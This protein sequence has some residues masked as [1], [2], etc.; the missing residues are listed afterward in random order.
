[1]RGA[2][3]RTRARVGRR[4][5]FLAF[6]AVLDA[7]FGYSL[8]TV[9]R[10]ALARADFILPVHAWGWTWIGTGVICASGILARKDRV[11]YTAAALLKTAW[12][13]LYAWLWWQGVPAAWVSV[14]VWLAFALVVVLVAGWPEEAAPPPPGP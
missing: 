2:L 6:L 13:L 4:G 14:T 1:M 12:G 10:A 9:P 3:T 11:Q 8:L 7:A 5:A